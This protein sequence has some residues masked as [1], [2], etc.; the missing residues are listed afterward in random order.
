[1]PLFLVLV[2]PS[3]MSLLCFVKKSRPAAIKLLLVSDQLKPEGMSK[4]ELCIVNCAQTYFKLQAA[5]TNTS[6]LGQMS[7]VRNNGGKWR[8]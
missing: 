6:C 7:V 8:G 4:A 3:G 5:N 1:M 2:F